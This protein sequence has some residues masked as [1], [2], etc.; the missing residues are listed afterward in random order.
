MKSYSKQET[1]QLL[2]EYRS[3]HPIYQGSYHE[4]KLA[5]QLERCEAE[6]SALETTLNVWHKVFG[7]TQLTH[8]LARLEVAE[9]KAERYDDHMAWEAMRGERE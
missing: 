5:T 4:D 6:R 3:L 8:A 2:A 7:T 1:E 9:R